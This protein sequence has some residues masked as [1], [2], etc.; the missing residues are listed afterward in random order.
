MSYRP[1][2]KLP[3]ATTP[4]AWTGV[5]GAPSWVEDTWPRE[6]DPYPTTREDLT[7]SVCVEA[8]WNS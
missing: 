8:C 7:F 5:A 6:D 3:C 4:R 1:L 2:E